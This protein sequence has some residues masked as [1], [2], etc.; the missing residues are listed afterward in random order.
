MNPKLFDDV[1]KI[2]SHIQALLLDINKENVYIQLRKC[3]ISI[4]KM[5]WD[6][7]I[8]KKLMKNFVKISLRIRTSQRIRTQNTI[9][10]Q[11]KKINENLER[12]IVNNFR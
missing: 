7:N 6:V 1:S 3:I 4:T 11:L 10:W 12:L 5:F 9:L 2:H 8:F